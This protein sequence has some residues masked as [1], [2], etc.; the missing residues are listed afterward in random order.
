MPTH[1]PAVLFFTVLFSSS[2]SALGSGQA[3]AV[4]AAAQADPSTTSVSPGS[5]S[6][7]PPSPPIDDPML[8]AVPPPRRIVS[9]W[10]EARSLL[11][12]RSTDLRAALDQVRQAH[13]Q[14]IVALA[15]YLPA[16]G[17]C[18]GGSSAP[19]GCA[20]A[21][22]THQ[23]ITRA[24]RENV[25]G[26]VLTNVVP[27]PNTLTASMT[28]SQD[29]VNVQE[30]DQIGINKLIEK[31]DQMT[32]DDTRRTL[33]LALA[34]QIVSV[35]TAER[36]AEI[37]REGLRVALEQ[38]YLTQRKAALGAAML[39]DVVRTKQ[40]A[41]N[42]RASLVNGDE[43][44][45]VARDSL[46]LALGIPEEVGVS[47]QMNVGGVA[48]DT[49]RSCR[50]VDNI[51]E[52]P[53]IAAARTGV[54]VAKRNLRNTWY[55]FIPVLTGQSTLNA[56]T[57]VNAGYPNPT[58]SIGAALSIPIFDGGTRW[59]TI[60]SERAAADISS[61]QLEGLRR[62]AIIQVEETG[63]EVEVAEASQRVATEQRDL[64]AQNDQLTQS[65]WARGIGTSVDLV[66]A[67]E[68]HRLA[69]QSLIVAELGVVKAHLAAL[70]ALATCPI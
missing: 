69:E 17:G 68:A 16:L 18:A 40:N 22:F 53:D 26:T 9:S 62:Q 46:G 42:A 21:S 23:L 49:I 64:A 29:I 31:Q 10:S 61:E 47:P 54:E 63:R 3:R 34:D 70:M 66:T 15:Q 51:D 33:E 5:P 2:W 19:P 11:A 1:R 43:T 32:V 48:E 55:S 59:G 25:T 12:A 50:P 58:W 24:A 7:A 30:F 4:P 28:L 56:T 44:L 35:V 14:T 27:I 41:A 45:R 8:A 20:N 39:L 38:L 57:A 6:T 37:N 52:R 13:G 36:T 65:L 60:T 67:S